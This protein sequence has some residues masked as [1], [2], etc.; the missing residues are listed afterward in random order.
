MF[1]PQ[2][3]HMFAGKIPSFRLLIDVSVRRP[4]SEFSRNYSKK[5]IKS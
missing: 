5:K 1:E 4:G 3:A 2:T